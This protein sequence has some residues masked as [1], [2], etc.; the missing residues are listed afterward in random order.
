MLV[1]RATQVRVDGIWGKS[2][3]KDLGR[4]T[5]LKTHFRT[6]GRDAVEFRLVHEQV[7]VN[8]PW[9]ELFGP[10]EVED[11]G[12]ERRISVDK[13]LQVDQVRGEREMNR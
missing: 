9:V 3:P 8:G 1:K 12:K 6:Q 13:D 2:A 5:A 11:G 7:H 4:H 10:Q